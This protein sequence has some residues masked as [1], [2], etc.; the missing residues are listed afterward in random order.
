MIRFQRSSKILLCGW[1]R[2]ILYKYLTSVLGTDDL[3][4]VCRYKHAK[5]V[6]IGP[7]PCEDK[8]ISYSFTCLCEG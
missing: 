8:T 4:E 3:D 5:L 1:D 2:I 7:L 6:A